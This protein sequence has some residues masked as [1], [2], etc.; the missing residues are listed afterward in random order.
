MATGGPVPVPTMSVPGEENRATPACAG[1]VPV[2]GPQ[3]WSRVIR[4]RSDVLVL[5]S[6]ETI[7][8]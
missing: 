2:T 4:N 7:E 1:G 5:A 8:Q 6:T 3:M